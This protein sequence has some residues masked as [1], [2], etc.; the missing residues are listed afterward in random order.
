MPDIEE[1]LRAMADVTAPPSTTALDDVLRRGRRRV[2][3]LRAG[4]VAGVVAVVAGAGFTAFALRSVPTSAPPADGPVD[5]PVVTS[6]TT[7]S[8]PPAW[9]P[10]VAL[11]PQTPYGTWQPASSAPPGPGREV[12]AVPQCD[13]HWDE[14]VVVDLGRDTVTPTAAERFDRAIDEVAGVAVPGEPQTATLGTDPAQ[15]THHRWVDVTDAGGTGSLTISEG[16]Y[17]GTP[18]EAAD[19]EAFLSGNC[20]PPH[21]QVRDD[22]TVLQYSSVIPSEPFQ[23]LTQRM[24]VYRSNGHVVEIV[25]RN[26]GTRDLRVNDADGSFERLGQGRATLPFS[27]RQF[28]AVG[29]EVASVVW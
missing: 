12:L 11:P 9:W 10:V 28:T 26:F 15:P 19:R 1:E 17:S 14:Q 3:A 16:R 24:R 23:S 13:S 22:G 5:G 8:G 25:Q 29:E 7:P 20:A 27:D 21:R 6:T 4:A 2:Y 18:L